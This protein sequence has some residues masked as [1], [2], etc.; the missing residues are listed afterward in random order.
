ME[1]KA[2]GHETSTRFYFFISNS[3][4]QTIL[5]PHFSLPGQT[6]EKKKCHSKQLIT[7]AGLLIILCNKTSELNSRQAGH[8][9]SLSGIAAGD[10][11]KGSA[12]CENDAF[13]KGIVPH[14]QYSYPPSLLID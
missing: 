2:R 6:N 13:P 5:I 4:Q 3:M 8:G 7:V 1:R 11:R 14:F 9:Y 10:S 12:F